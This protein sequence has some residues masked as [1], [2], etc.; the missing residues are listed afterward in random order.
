MVLE[1][2]TYMHIFCIY[3]NVFA[4]KVFQILLKIIWTF[5]KVIS[6]SK[7]L[8]NVLKY[9]KRFQ[10]QIFSAFLLCTYMN[11]DSGLARGGEG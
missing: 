8:S 3:I 7:S 11:I 9:K 1:F 5:L 10:A 2:V 4:V 6:L